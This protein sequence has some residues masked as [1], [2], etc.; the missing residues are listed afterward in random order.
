MDLNLPDHSRSRAILIGTSVY[1]DQVF[2]PLPAA[3]NSLHG[4]RDVLAEPSLCRW[5]A[6][7]ITMLADPVDAPRLIQQLRRLARETT[8]VLLIYFVGHGTLLRRGQLC[9]ILRDTESSD[10]DITGL[11]YQRIRE[12]LLDS[13]AQIKVTILDCCYS[14]RAIEALSAAE[15]IADSTFTRGT[16]TLTASDQTAHVPP[17]AQQRAALTSFT[18]EL[19]DLV[20]A[21]LPGGPENLALHELYLHLRLRLEA[22]G[23]PEPNQRGTDTAD[24]FTFTRNAAWTAAAP[25]PAQPPLRAPEAE[26]GT[27]AEAPA[28]PPERTRTQPPA[29]AAPAPSPA[30]ASP[31][32][33]ARADP[34]S[35]RDTGRT[36]LTRPRVAALTGPADPGL[37]REIGLAGATW[38]SETSM[39]GSGW[40]FGAFLAAQAAGPAALLGWVIGGIIVMVLALVHAELGAMY[41]VSGGTARFP[42][43]AFGSGAGISFGFFSWLQAVTV[44]PVECFAVMRYGSYGWHGLFNVAT[45][46]VTGLGFA[47]A[48][49]LMAV[50]TGLNFTA[51]EFLTRINSAITWWKVAIPVLAVIVLLTKFNGGN[52]TAGGGFVPFGVKALFAAIPSAGIVFGYFGF[53]QAVQLAGEVRNPQRNVPW[54]IIVACVIGIAFYVLVQFAFIGAI[55]HRLISG[56]RGWAGIASIPQFAAPPPFVGLAGLAGFGWLAVILRL[57]AVVSPFGTGL[58]YQTSAARVGYGLARNRYT[59]QA[60]GRTSM[61]G[62]PWVSLIVAFG[63]GLVFLLPSPSWHS[64]V[65]VVT[66]ASVLMYAG[67]PLSLGAFR[68]QVPDAARPYRMPGAVLMAPLAFVLASLIIYWSGFDVLWKLGVCIAIGYVITIVSMMFDP[69]RPPLD[70]WSAQWLPAYLIGLGIISWQG[71]FGAGAPPRNTGRIPFGWD[72]LIVAVFSLVIYYWAMQ[73]KLPREYVLSLVDRQAGEEPAPAATA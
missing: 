71:Q 41:P 65:G 7:R 15:A 70:W 2:P 37:K 35:A 47:M 30:V 28:A 16:Y 8:G 40:L 18:G 67:A 39:I 68:S 57:D 51:I 5:P 56:P 38:V 25:R 61:N 12:V 59:W 45:G 17:L 20:R 23:L 58:I 6:E 46:N 27:A 60:L 66:S 10:P 52:L 73:V 24:L 14:G 36:G 29:R 3:R 69:Q 19:I 64:L 50:F 4:F 34:P 53:E 72:M 33:P 42:H 13:P 1:N 55:P 48:V 63:F 9:L 43:F 31:G 21:G 26:P 11:E 22:R 54:A 49:L 32:R 62:V 44:A